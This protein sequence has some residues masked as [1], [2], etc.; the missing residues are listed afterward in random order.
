MHIV[1]VSRVFAPEASAATPILTS[2]ARTFQRSGHRV[3][4]LTARLPRGLDDVDLPGVEIKRAPVLRDRQGYVRGYLQ[5]LSFDLPLAFRM[6]ARR[7]ADLYFVEP[8]PTTGAVVRIVAGILR[9]PY[10]YRAADVWS[11][12]AHMATGSRIVVRMLRMVERFA[13]RGCRIAFA[14]SEGVA[15]R[16]RELG[17][18]S[19]TMVTGWGVDTTIFRFASGRVDDVRPY[20]VYA[21]THSE[22]HGAGIFIDAFAKVRA[23]HPNVRLVFVGNGSEREALAK[24]AASLGL[25]TVEFRDAVSGPELAPI[26]AGALASLAS[27]KPGQ[28]YDYAFTTKAFP[29]LAV[30]C[31]VVFAGVGPT[32]AFIDDARGAHAVGEAVTYDVDE[33]AAAMDRALAKPV[34]EADRRATAEWTARHF[35]VD[36]IAET[37][38]SAATSTGESAGS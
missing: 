7:R 16:M 21:G 8:P 15:N 9:R 26:L 12:A 1:V 32:R 38:L 17:V 3:T 10:F 19:R 31:P 14:T 25:T 11:D 23:D 4:V 18:E 36:S 30:G 27:L 5:Y 22:W 28:G 35:S 2:V 20:L 34:T 37:I 6:L 33:V 29:S 24:K 13:F